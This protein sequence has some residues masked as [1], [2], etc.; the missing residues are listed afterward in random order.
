MTKDRK[1]HSVIARK[2]SDGN[3]VMIA[4]KVYKK[5][6][7]FGTS[8]RACPLEKEE[9]VDI[10]KQTWDSN[11]YQDVQ[12]LRRNYDKEGWFDYCATIVWSNGLWDGSA[13]DTN[14]PYYNFKLEYQLQTN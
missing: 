10:A 3:W 12:V 14:C 6:S 5:K 11:K 4:P 2:K 9:A 8:T 13:A 1:A 7:W